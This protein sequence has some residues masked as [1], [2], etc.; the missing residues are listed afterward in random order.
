MNTP[1]LAIFV[2]ALAGCAPQADRGKSSMAAAGEPVT[3]A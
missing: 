2:L 1:L 3:L